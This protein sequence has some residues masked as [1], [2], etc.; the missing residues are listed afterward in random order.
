MLDWYVYEFH[1]TGRQIPTMI[2]LFV[3]TCI[4][5]VVFSRDETVRLEDQ[6][7]FTTKSLKANNRVHNYI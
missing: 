4:L 5:H 1:Q 6:V 7:F 2:D 3:V